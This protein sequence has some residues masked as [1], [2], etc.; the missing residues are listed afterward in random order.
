MTESQHND[1]WETVRELL[2]NRIRQRWTALQ[3]LSGSDT[4]PDIIES[5]LASVGD[6]PKSLWRL[7]EQIDR[8]LDIAFAPRS[9]RAPSPGSAQ[10]IREFKSR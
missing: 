8:Q 3:R 7:A 10:Y 2:C 6:D 9:K 1:N 4:H 5:R